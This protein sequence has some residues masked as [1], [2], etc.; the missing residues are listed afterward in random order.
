MKYHLVFFFSF[1][2]S[3]MLF[4]SCTIFDSGDLAEEG[5]EDYYEEVEAEAEDGEQPIDEEEEDVYYIDEEDEEGEDFGEAEPIEVEDV[6][7]DDLSTDQKEDSTEYN[8]AKDSSSFFSRESELGSGSKAAVPTIKKKWISYKRIKSQ[9]YQVGDFLVNAVYIARQKESI[10]SISNKIFSS[11]QVSQLYSINPHLK[12]RSVKVG[13]KIY[14]QSPVRPQDSS[15][16]LFY[17]EDNG[18]Q[19]EYHQIQAGQNIRK[20][21]SQLLGHA[22]SWKEIWAT[23]SNLD[24]KGIVNDSITIRYW[25]KGV[26][27]LPP[28]VSEPTPEPETPIEPEPIPEEPEPVPEEEEIEEQ[29]EQPPFSEE[30]KVSSDPSSPSDSLD[31]SFL[32]N[33]RDRISTD[34]MIGIILVFIA[35][36]FAVIIVKRRNKRKDFDY[37]AT[38]FEIDE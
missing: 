21:A 25:P 30:E 19:P 17:F 24:S 38:S 6:V 26:S 34:I 8:T 14:Y 12:A 11:N 27:A 10:Q 15:Q 7:S 9:P 33:I 4:S 18:I 3:F 36:L 16:L 22:N 29:P 35:V 32:N 28:S 1:L 13:D 5:E 31:D 37:T 2:V 23:N 20:V